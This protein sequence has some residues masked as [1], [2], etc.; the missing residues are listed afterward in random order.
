MR[1]LIDALINAGGAN[2]PAPKWVDEAVLVEHKVQPW[3]GLPLWIPASFGD[4][5][6]FMLIDCTK[7]QRAGLRTRPL[8]QTIRDTA[9]WLGQRDNASAW[10]LVLGAD[11]E[12]AIAERA[13]AL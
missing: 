1:D 2:A 3:T 7:A 5:A 4:E 13:R 9:Q 8:D 12:R 6:G 11:K 10:K